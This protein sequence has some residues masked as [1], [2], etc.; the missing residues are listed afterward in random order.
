MQKKHQT[1]IVEGN[2]IQ[3]YTTTSDDKD[4]LNQQ[5]Q[6]LVSYLSLCFER[7]FQ[8]HSADQRRPRQGE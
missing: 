6:Q 3:V 4:Y 5:L 8:Q 7:F 1:I 2:Y